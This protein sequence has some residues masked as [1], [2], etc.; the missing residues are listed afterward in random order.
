MY[1]SSSPFFR[2]PFWSFRT[3]ATFSSCLAFA[4]GLVDTAAAA[5]GDLDTSFGGAA[6]GKNSVS[7]GASDLVYGS[8]LQ[9]DGKMLVVGGARP[10]SS[11]D[12]G[13]AR[14]NADGTLDTA[15]ATNGVYTLNLS[16]AGTPTDRATAVGVQSDGTIIISG[17]TRSVSANNNF[18]VIRLSAAGVRDM[19]FAGTGVA[20]HDFAGGN[21]SAFVMK[22][23]NDD[24]IVVVGRVNTGELDF[25]VLRLL[26]DGSLDT[27]FGTNGKTTFSVGDSEDTPNAMLIDSDGKIL[28]GGVS[29]NAGGTYRATLIRLNA[30]GS[31]DGTFATGGVLT[32]NTPSSTHD[33]IRGIALQ[34]DGKIVVCGYSYSIG[35]ENAFIARFTTSGAFDTTFNSIGYRM[36]DMGST[37]DHLN[38]VVIQADGKIVAGGQ[39][40][41]GSNVMDSALVRVTSAGAMDATFGNSGITIVSLETGNDKIVGLGLQASGLIVAATEVSVS[42]GAEDFGVARFLNTVQAGAAP[43]LSAATYNANTGVL[44]VTAADMTTGDTISVDKLTLTG[45]GGTTYT[46]TTSDVT[47]SSATAFSVTLN[48]TDRNAVNQ[49]LNRNGTSSTSGTTYN[50]AAA[51]DWNASVT[52]GDTAD[53]TNA[54]TVSNVAVPTITSATYDA[55]TGVL[56]VTGTGF[57]SR[58]GAMN[59]IVA[60]RFTVTGEGGAT[61]TLTDSMNVEITSGTAFTLTLSATDRTA[62][63]QIINKNGTSSTGGT[64]YNLAAAEDW[65]A[66][67][68]P[69]VNVADLTG[70]GITASNVLILPTVTAANISISGAT[71]TGGVFRIGD[72]VTATWNNTAGGDNN[73]G[74]TG[75]TVNFSAFG[76]GSAVVA[77]NSSGTWTATYTIS[78]GAIDATN[79]NVSVSA[80]NA[81]GTTTRAD[82]T[83]AS[84]DNIAPTVT[85]AR[86]SISGASGTGGAFRIG[87]TATATWNNT[88][89]GDNNSDTISSVT[90]DFTQ[91][92]G[93]AA[94]P[95]TNSS[96]TWTATFTIGS[97]AIDATNRNISVTATDNAGNSTTTADTT[98]ATVD[99]IAPSV[100]AANISLSGA[101]GTGGAYKIGDTVTVTWNNTAGGDNNSD[102][103]SGVTVNFSQFGGGA[104]VAA[105]NSAGTWTAT[106]TITAGAINGTTNRNVAVTATDNAGNSTTTA[107]TTNATVDN[108]APT[109]PSTP[110]LT[111]ASDSGASST[112][113]ITN[114]TTPTF[115]G[116]AEANSTVTLYDTDGTTVLGTATATG[117][118][119][120]ITSSPLSAGSHSITARATDGAGNTSPASSALAITIDTTPPPAPAFTAITDDTGTS[121]TD[122]ITSDT[123]L[124]L[125]G[126]AEAHATVA[127]FRNTAPIGSTSADGTGYWSFDYTGTSLAEGLHTFTATATDAAGNTSPE[128]SEF[129]VE[130]D[131]ATPAAPII[132]G[133]TTDSGMSSTD[134]ITNDATLVLT[135]TA[136]PNTT[137]TL[138]RS[139]VGVLGTTSSNGSGTWTFDY[140][141]TTLPDGDYL[142]TAFATDTAGNASTA[143][144]D[145][146][147]TIDTTA[148][149]IA[150]QPVGGTFV[151]GSS[152]DLT[153][154]ASDL[155]A[156][157]YTWY[158]DG[159]PLSDTTNRSGS[160]TATVTHSGIGTIGFAGDYTV[161]ITDAAGNSRTSN[162]ASVIVNKADQTI[163]FPAISDQLATNA[164]F[165]VTAT[166]STGFGV[167]FSVVSG[168]ASVSGNTVTL[169]GAGSVTIRA[170]QAGDLNYNSTTADRTFTVNKD[171]ATIT[172]GDLVTTYNGAAHSAS[173]S[174][175][176]TG[177]TVVIT[178]DGVTTPPTSAGSYAVSA[179]ID[180]A[181]YSGST[182]DTLQ[183]ARASQTVTFGSVGTVTIGQPLA[184]NAGASS[185]LPVTLSLLSGPATL[186]GN[187]L[188]VTEGGTVVVRA[189]QAG[190]NNHLPSTNDLSLDVGRL[191][192]TITFAALPDRP[193]THPPFA[194]A[195]T[196]S[197]GLPVS[198]AV[199]DGPAMLSGSTLTLT[200]TP[201]TVV[202]RAS[203][204]GSATY[205]PAQSVTRSF[206]VTAVGPLVYFGTMRRG[207]VV[208]E[209][210]AEI[211]I[212]GKFGTL[213]GIIP[214]TGEGFIAHFTVGDDGNWS[215]S[216]ETFGGSSNPSESALA[217]EGVSSSGLNRSAPPSKAISRSTTS[218]T[219]RGT[220]SDGVLT[221]TIDGTDFV[222]T[223]LLQ[224]PA[225]PTSD[226]AGFYE[227]ASLN[228]ATGASYSIVGTQANVYTLVVTHRNVVGSTGVITADGHFNITVPGGIELSG[229]V[230]Q[231]STSVRTTLVLPGGT[232]ESFSGVR[233]TTLRTDR[234]VNL[235]TRALFN[236]QG[237]E[238]TLIAGFVIGGQSSKKVL[239]RG[240]GPSLAPLGVSSALADPR[241]RVLDA[242]G[243]LVAE[244]DNWG[245]TDALASTMRR[246]GAFAL[247][248]NSKDAAVLLDLPPGAYTVQ[249]LDGGQSGIALA[250]IYDASESPER[251]Y[252]RL[253]NISS[254]GKVATGEGVL[255]GG[256]VVTG[257]APKRV[258]VR[259]S[260]PALKSFGVAGTLADPQLR[261]YDE[262]G[263]LIGRNDDWGTPLTVS[264]YQASASA[265]EINA[266]AE[267]SGAFAFSAGSKDAALIITLAPG[268]YTVHLSG[269]NQSTGVGLIEIYE[270]P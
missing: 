50:L 226:V 201:G 4:L 117:G 14:F 190:D 88:A 75:V 81:D 180:D 262:A 34:S 208:Q 207:E 265:A 149:A 40:R 254:R 209:I 107:D 237:G 240:V 72:T 175:S 42:S 82:T 135:G 202:V 66:G 260:G 65:A 15:F 170:T 98:N 195:A 183:I 61:Y 230:D 3:V 247:P 58:S 54:V 80:T 188:T 227:A 79:R 30:N 87:D 204:A 18:A 103:I 23:L 151:A 261:V 83:N 74:I 252:Q 212:D 171:T 2:R 37:I 143:S 52:S 267:Q 165:P 186:T 33:T 62:V 224:P 137:I 222:F 177:L 124:V 210:A 110:D 214:G 228:S 184:L 41:N 105:T 196:A 256:F 26:A 127:V 200:G 119:W 44:A 71:G 131:I 60:N 116:T 223:A 158:L 96:G 109:A 128:S 106:Y 169:T 17:Y 144:A 246:V 176:P 216:V 217:S 220:T 39:Y 189:S 231:S 160:T 76:G 199:V 235:S 113:N 225:G 245:G 193:A 85:D 132:G 250:E 20:E 21:D 172:L 248:A 43:S 266:A 146:P 162:V 68:D 92:G 153:V 218:R 178:Y 157:T 16:V 49:I 259:G 69:A 173:V 13:L 55:S 47:A 197:S 122:Q 138:S 9:S 125:S 163:T 147:V 156:L 64:T 84:V 194:L 264:A 114:V 269:T 270:I 139:G 1:P 101:S 251:E 257:N 25:G 118:N 19:T 78:A 167:T 213:L 53:A 249:V 263:A 241:L 5:D 205:S 187:T 159:N 182:S 95:A 179:T 155:G 185:G 70:N 90:V 211:S 229:Q 73:A 244:N 126:T 258:L 152:F 56:V 100:T 48:A 233:E 99:N 191:A 129:L 89:G 22:V 130:I 136:E 28:I 255:I 63:N 232:A 203:Q 121:S 219:F 31:L 234:L 141:G 174:T 206:A 7:L 115:T 236:G 45:E 215:T 36:I 164:P 111:A 268:S 38:S 57:L 140:T 123:T 6:S 29:A 150:T 133:I 24:R 108:V 198:F 168:P 120:S 97:G 238:G 181:R 51:D 11:E 239:L 93:G 242:K 12:F 134:G 243:N 104:A 10:G 166:A 94:V 8:H 35:T 59:D 91:F 192:Q 86:I 27:T 221:G 154:A 161:V 112:D 145:F 77:T 67:A 32:F 142:F 148:P 46:L 102:T 253:I